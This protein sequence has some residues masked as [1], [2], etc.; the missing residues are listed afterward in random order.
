MEDENSFEDDIDLSSIKYKEPETKKEKTKTDERV[1]P[2]LKEIEKKMKK[3]KPIKEKPTD[4]DIKK[5]RSLILL[6]QMYINEFPKLKKYKNTN[7]EKKTLDELLDLRKEFDATLSCRSTVKAGVNIAIT[8][9]QTL[10]YVLCNFT[11]IQAQGLS[12]VI[13]DPDVI[14][15]IKILVLKHMPLISSEPE[16]RILFKLITTTMQLHAINTYNQEIIHV[17]ND[18]KKMENVEI[19]NGEYND[20]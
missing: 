13:N 9:I 14:E 10:E 4:D 11:P 2:D 15:D 7:F 17:N 8:V 20:I 16:Q 5:R 18:S 3:V 1:A 12:N 6:M 19:I